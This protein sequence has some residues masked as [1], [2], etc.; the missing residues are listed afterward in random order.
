MILAFIFIAVIILTLYLC[1]CYSVYKEGIMDIPVIRGV[2]SE[3]SS[4]ELDHYVM[5]NP[6]CVVY[7]C[8]ASDTKCRS[9]E[10]DFIK[11]INRKNLQ[12][13]I[14]YLN[15]SNADSDFTD[16][17]NSTY[18]YKIK[19]TT[20]YPAIVIFEDGN[21]ASLLQEE[22][23]LSITRAKQFIELNKIGE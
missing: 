12:E 6:N 10:E 19:L 9:F 16:K 7:I 1:D 3:I 4:D 22:D 17:F 15:V 8:T 21:I 18:N 14:I 11:L 5:E 20:N 23:T 13:E 2:V